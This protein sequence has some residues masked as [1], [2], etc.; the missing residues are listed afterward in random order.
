MINRAPLYTKKII[1]NNFYGFFEQK[2]L[3]FLYKKQKKF[4]G[5]R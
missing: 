2:L 4:R 1:Y 5:I 3:I